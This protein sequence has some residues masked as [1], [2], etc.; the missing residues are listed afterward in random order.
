MTNMSPWE[1]L[2]LNLPS[3]S[4]TEALFAPLTRTVAAG[5][6]TPELSVTLPVMTRLCASDTV[7]QPSQAHSNTS[8]FLISVNFCVIRLF[9]DKK[10]NRKIASQ[11]WFVTET[12]KAVPQTGIGKTKQT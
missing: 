10:I 3:L 6:P 7:I 12:G 1:A 11:K 2:M 8:S 5:M 9:R 4:A